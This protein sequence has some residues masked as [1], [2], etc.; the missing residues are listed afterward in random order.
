M[1]NVWWWDIINGVDANDG[2]TE[3]TPVRTL[4]RVYAL[5]S[6]GDRVIMAPGVY[7]TSVTAGSVAFGI[8]KTIMFTPKK[9]G[10][11]IW[12]FEGSLPGTANIDVSVSAIFRGLHFRN[13]GVGKYAFRRT[14][15][16]PAFIDCVFY[17]RDGAANT[18]RGI[19]GANLATLI[20]N[21]SFYNLQVGVESGEAYS[22]YF[23]DTTT[24]FS[25]TVTRDYN[26]FPGNTETNGINTSTGI[27]PGFLDAGAEDFRLDLSQTGAPEAYR[28]QGRFDGPIGA[29]GAPGP[30]W[31]ARWAQSRWMVPD[32]TPEGSMIGSWVNDADYQDPSGTG[33][34]GE[35]VEDTG[36]FEPIIDLS[37]GGNPAALSGRILSQ[38]F[39]WGTSGAVLNAFPFAGFQDPPAGAVFDTNTSY[40]AKAEY[41]QS[42]TLF[43]FDDPESTDLQWIEYEFHEQLDLSER[44]QQFRITF[45]V[46]HTN[47]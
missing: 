43:L 5:A 26:A 25:G 16:T 31:D 47:A 18:G 35:I 17:Q 10:V 37:A 14:G 34:T 29:T 46:A 38:V 7:P 40:P 22:C 36:D 1:A 11:V 39:D 27:D 41:R 15:G 12:D 3:A 19:Q 30:W 4:T 2:A 45:Q 8:A 9:A 33:F 13:M 23:K 44:Y 24:P 21:C 32:P 20:E 28:T 6:N 42:S